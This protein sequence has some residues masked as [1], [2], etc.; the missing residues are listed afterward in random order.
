MFVIRLSQLLSVFCLV[1]LLLTSC[2]SSRASVSPSSLTLTPMIMLS[3]AQ[4]TQAASSESTTTAGPPSVISA[5]LPVDKAQ[6]WIGSDISI[7]FSVS[8]DKDATVAALVL[9][10]TINYA[11]SWK[12][13]FATMVIHPMSNW[14]LLSTYTLTIKAQARSSNGLAIGQDYSASFTVTARPESPKV[15][16][17]QPADGTVDVLPEEVIYITF[18]KPMNT[19]ATEESLVITPITDLAAGY[20]ILWDNVNQRLRFEFHQ[21][22]RGGETYTIIV[23]QAAMSVDG[24]CLDADYTFS[25]VVMAC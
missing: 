24:V 14:V 6:N 22:M 18:S 10:P 3:T 16:S 25:F 11:I 5:S 21:N 4:T 8:M 1:F 19:V 20:T 23:T 17:T 7:N 13:N 9:S 15:I 2:Q 12:N